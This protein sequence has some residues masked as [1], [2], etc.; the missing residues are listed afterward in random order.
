MSRSPTSC[1]TGASA[2]RCIGI[3]SLLIRLCRSELCGIAPL[4]F[5]IVS[6]SFQNNQPLISHLYICC[7][8]CK[9]LQLSIRIF[10]YVYTLVV[11]SLKSNSYIQYNTLV[12]HSSILKSTDLLDPK[13]RLWPTPVPQVPRLLSPVVQPSHQDILVITKPLN[14]FLGI[15]GGQV[16]V[17]L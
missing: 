17:N 8:V 7:I 3:V 5:S 10:R 1:K 6:F 12:W 16:V 11:F 13:L 9:V 15:I 2:S 4:S 14:S